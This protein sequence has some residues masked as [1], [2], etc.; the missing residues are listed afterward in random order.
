MILQTPYTPLPP[1][2]A[3]APKNDLNSLAHLFN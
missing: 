3:P 1:P 2:P